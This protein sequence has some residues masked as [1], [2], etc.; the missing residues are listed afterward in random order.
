LHK[1]D[2]IKNQLYRRE[3]RHTDTSGTNQMVQP[4]EE[5]SSAKRNESK[6]EK[7]RRRDY[8]SLEDSFSFAN[9]VFEYGIGVST[10]VASKVGVPR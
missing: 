10:R 6:R 2:A 9:S 7:V 3:S 8:T 5:L 1:F 4:T